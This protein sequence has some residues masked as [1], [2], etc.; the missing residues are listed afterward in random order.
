MTTETKIENKINGVDLTRLGGVIEAVTEDN[1]LAE[2]KFRSSNEWIDGGHNRS[3]IKN[4]Y[5]CGQEDTSRKASFTYN[6]DEPDVL[7]GSDNGANPVE[8][9]LHALAG[10]MTTTMVYHA[11]ARGIVIEEMR[12]ELEGELDLRGFLGMDESVRPGYQKIRAKFKV[13]SNA[14]EEQLRELLKFSP[15]CDSVCHPVTVEPEFEMI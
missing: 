12:S 11:A 2:F 10:C 15:M 6:A 5:G 4:F 14:T 9:L 3:S 13:K 7:L 1:T 8:Y